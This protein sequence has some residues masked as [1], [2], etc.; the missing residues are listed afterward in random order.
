M[1]WVAGRWGRLFLLALG[2]GAALAVTVLDDLR[3]DHNTRS[4]LREDPVADAREADLAATFGSED[5][6]LVAWEVDRATDLAEFRRL[7]AVAADLEDIAGLEEMYSLASPRVQ[8]PIGAEL[9]PIREEDLM[10]EAGRRAVRDALLSAPVYRGTIYNPALD[11]V[12]VAG[13]LKQAERAER[14][15]TLRAVRAVARKHGRPGRPLHVAGV[16]ALAVDAG[17]YAVKDLQRIGSW[18]LIVSAAVLFFL[19]RSFT[20]T[21]VALLATGLPPLFALASGVVL[22]VPVTAL[23]AALFPVLAV[24]GITSSVH[25]LNAYGEALRQGQPPDEAAATAAT[26]LAAPIVLS[27]ATTAAAFV[28]LQATGVPAFRFGGYIVAL[29]MLVAIPVVLFGLPAALALL[30]PPARLAGAGRLDRPLLAVARWVL[31]HRARVLVVGAAVCVAGAALTTRA[32][33]QVDVLQAFKP[34]SD[35]ARTYAFLERRLTAVIPTDAVLQSGAGVSEVQVLRE[36]ETFSERAREDAHVGSALSLATL[37]NFG[38]RVSPIPV[39]DRGALAVLRTPLFAPIT[40]RFEDRDKNRYRVK[41]RIREGA[42]PEVLDR[43]ETHAGAFTTGEAKLTGLYVRAVGTTRSVIRDL[44]R[45]SLLMAALVVVTVTLALRSWRLGIA[46]LVP[47]LLPPA[48]VF[49]GAALLGI[50]LDVSAVAV[51]AV[52]IGLAVDDTLHVV[53]RLAEARRRGLDLEAAVAEA[54]RSVGRALVLST[55]VLTAGLVCLAFSAFKPTAHFGLFTAA[56]CAVALAAD[57]LVL[58]A[59]V[60]GFRAL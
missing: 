20:E 46:A 39:D 18:A 54:H 33:L 1:R 55:V 25:L 15:A 41:L 47:N 24:V 17:E 49:G 37:V 27:L 35:I 19:C 40:Q 8:L 53:F 44:A 2:L 32:R 16:T 57:L 52:A 31:V 10:S 28:S 5:L 23:G 29:G 7:R 4:L 9:R 50:P 30:R 45:G 11:V 60:R 38:K 12:A 21:L 22:E 6:L 34:E 3:F 58:P 26:R 51:G 42:P 43:L 14:E 13:T 36:L 48:A 56:A 59:F